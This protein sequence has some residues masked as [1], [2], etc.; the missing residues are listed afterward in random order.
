[1]NSDTLKLCLVEWPAK[2]A[3]IS[4]AAALSP[5]QASCW[6]T[7]SGYCPQVLQGALTFLLMAC[8][9]NSGGDSHWPISTRWSPIFTTAATPSLGPCQ[10]CSPCSNHQRSWEP[11]PEPG[12]G[13]EREAIDSWSHFH[14][15]GEEAA[16]LWRWRMCF[17]HFQRLSDVR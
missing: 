11:C 6:R 8:R 15:C 13:G 1:M 4:Q 17:Q 7:I 16:F 14:S 12:A 9:W 2:H 3:I 5:R 10:P